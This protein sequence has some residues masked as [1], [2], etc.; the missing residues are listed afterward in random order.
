MQ[1]K[2]SLV[3]PIFLLVIYSFWYCPND[4]EITTHYRKYNE[5]ENSI[6]VAH[7]SDL[8]TK[9]VGTVEEKL[10]D[11]LTKANPDVIVITGDLAAPGGSRSGYSQVLGKL[12]APL[13]VYFIKGNWEYWESISHL[14]EL[15]Q[16]K[17]ILDITNKKVQLKKGA[18]LAGFDDAL[19]GEPDIQLLESLKG[20]DLNI[21]IFHTPVFF[22]KAYK[23]VDLSLAGHTHGGQVRLPYFGPVWTPAG[24]GEYVAGWYS[25]GN[26]AL[27]VSRGIGTSMLPVRFNCRPELAVFEI[28]Y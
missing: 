19:E 28:S 25:K 11:A 7:V 17:G 27:Y 20:S 9:E 16:S 6:K 15:L 1:K 23:F 10:F 24:T 13:G 4:L 14:E 26:S 3:I 2:I 5:A 8:H 12:K 22:K 18:W 21:G